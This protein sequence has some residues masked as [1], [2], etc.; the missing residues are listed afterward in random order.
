MLDFEE[1]DG[2]RLLQTRV[3]EASITINNEKKYKIYETKELAVI[4]RF[5]W[6]INEYGSKAPQ[7]YKIKRLFPNLYNAV[8]Y[9][10][11]VKDNVNTVYKILKRLEQ[12][13]HC[14]CRL[15]K[16]ED[17]ICVCREFKE[18]NGGTC[19]CG[20]FEKKNEPKGADME[21]FFVKKLTEDA[22]L[23]TQAHPGDAGWD[24][25]SNISCIVKAGETV[26]IGTGI[27][28]Q[29][30]KNTFGAVFARSGLATK[31]GL[32]PANCVGVCDSGY[33]GEYIVALHNDSD[34]DSTIMK[35]DRVAQLVVIPYVTGELCVVDDLDKTE[36]GS[37]GFGSTGKN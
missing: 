11:G 19:H 26:K 33:T 13:K 15:K 10:V 12:D 23:P 32:R 30:P 2:V 27:S 17:T 34:E 4:Q 16:T 9:N 37:G 31:Q 36:R 1:I 24:L 35:G 28:I 22:I 7:I 21:K 3:W 6:E 20:L 25:Y 14:P 29:L 18:Q 8:L 5:I